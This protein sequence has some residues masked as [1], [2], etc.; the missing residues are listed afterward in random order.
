MCVKHIHMI[1]QIA[2]FVGLTLLLGVT[3]SSAQVKG[4]DAIKIETKLVSV[5]TIVSDRD[6]RYVPNLTA[7]D[8]TVF[9]DGAKQNIE[10]FAATE[11]PISV[12]LLID[13]SQSTRPVLGDIKD[14]AKAFLKL[15]GPRDN[16][17][18]VSFDYDTHFLSPL[19]SDQE[20]LKKAIK[21]ADVPRGQVG[22]TLRDA[23]FQT[24]NNVFK[25]LTGRKAI[26]LLTDGKDHGSQ[27]TTR[28]LLFRLEESDTLIFTIFL[29]QNR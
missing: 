7:A 24:V 23:V 17:M 27:I 8:F 4:D 15:L 5:P 14:S 3:I 12:A 20:Q 1:R 19:T 18:I 28:D 2:V 22:T 29:F 26:I 25:G 21:Q 11:E 16:A 6:G 10:F 9:Q 13:T